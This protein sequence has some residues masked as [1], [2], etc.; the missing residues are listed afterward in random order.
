MKPEPHHPRC[1]WCGPQR[2]IGLTGGI[3]TGKSTVAAILSDRHGLPVLDADVYARKLLA[4]GTAACQAVLDRYGQQVQT[5]GGALDRRALGRIVFARPGERRWLEVLIH[6]LV[7]D[8]FTR[9]LAWHHQV[10]T[11]VLM[12]PLLFEAGLE[13]LCSEVWLVDLDEAGQLERLLARDHLSPQEARQRIQAQWPLARKRGLADVIL[14]N[15]GDLVELARQVDE[16]LAKQAPR[17]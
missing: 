10:A 8:A 2:R 6:P 1:R 9:D 16:A 12:A 5:P 7:K 14:K 11:V 17:P 13:A 15:H 4:P 3:A